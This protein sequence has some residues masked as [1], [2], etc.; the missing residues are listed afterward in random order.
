LSSIETD[1]RQG[2]TY[3]TQREAADG[4]ATTVTV[5]DTDAESKGQKIPTFC[6]RWGFSRA[7]FYNLEKRGLAPKTIYVGRRRLISNAQEEI[8]R[9]KMEELAQRSPPA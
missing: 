5:S 9:Q 1:G 4:T 8:W 2:D 3:E 6:R 7:H